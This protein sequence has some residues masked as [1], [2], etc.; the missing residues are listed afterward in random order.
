V[1]ISLNEEEEGIAIEE[2]NGRKGLT[3]CIGGDAKWRLIGIGKGTKDGGI[4]LGIGKKWLIRGN[5]LARRGI[6]LL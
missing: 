5:T 1:G 3:I 2:L 6:S 4:G